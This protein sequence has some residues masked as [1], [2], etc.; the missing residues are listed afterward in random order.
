MKLSKLNNKERIQVLRLS[1]KTLEK[2]KKLPRQL[3]DAVRKV[4]A[5]AEIYATLMDPDPEH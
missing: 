4:I 3:G 2:T 1:L 5:T